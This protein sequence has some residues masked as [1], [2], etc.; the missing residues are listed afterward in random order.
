MKKNLLL[1]IVSLFFTEI[2]F[3]QIMPD[4]DFPGDEIT[5]YRDL[6]GDGYGN[7][8]SSIQSSTQPNGYV[9]N[10]A[11]CDDSNPNI[12][13]EKFW[14]RDSDGDGYGTPS[15]KVLSCTALSGYVS[16]SSDCNDSNA[17]LPKYFYKDNDGDGYG[18][19]S[20]KLLACS[21]PSGYVSNTS[22]CNDSNAS[23]PK[24][25]Y[26]DSDGDGYGTGIGILDCNQPT[27]TNPDGS[28]A[29]SNVNGDCN[30][31]NSN[32][33]PGALEICDGIDNDCDGQI[34]EAPKPSTPSAPT[35]TKNCGSTVLT[36]STP[37]SG[38]T[39]YWQSSS[40][41][42]S[43]GNSNTS[44]TRTSGTVYYL[45][46]R[47]NTTRCWS[48]VRS[49]SYS[50]NTVPSTPP[51]PTITKNCGNTVLTKGSSPSGITWYWQSSSSGT[52]TSNS[53]TSI[54]RTSGTVYYLRARN[55]TSGC[56]SSTRSVSYSINTIPSTP[57]TPIVTKNCGNT[58]L[59]RGTPPSGITWYWQ[60]SS[61]GTSTAN[62]NSSITRTS[63]TVYY[64]RARNNTTGCWSSTR[65]VSYSINTVPSTPSTPTIT[66]NC[67]NTVLTRGTP[68]S[69]ISWYWQSTSSGT[70]TGNSNTSI[71][72]TSGTV[73]YLRARNNTSGC[74]SS[75][76]S[77]SYSINTVPSTPPTP[78]IT[79]NC[80]NT[81][82]TKGSSPSGITWYWQSS[83]SGTNTSN[84]NTSITRTSGTVYYLRARN[85]TSGCWSSVR[86][87]S[88]SINSPSTWYADTDGDGYGDTNNTTSACETPNGYVSNN[89]D[90]DDSTNLITN[91]TPKNYYRDIDNDGYGNLSVKVYQS[92]APT[93][94]VTNS[95]DCNDSNAALHPN[96]KWYADTDGDGFGDPNSVKTQCAQPS[97]YVLSKEDNCPTIKGTYF[98][99]NETQTNYSAP[100]L[101]DENY[102]FI[103]EY[104]EAKATPSMIAKNSDVI[105]N[106]T[107]FDGLGR[108]KQQIAIRGGVKQSSSAAL[109]LLASDWLEGMGSTSFYNQNG[110]TAENQRVLGAS[111][112]GTK[113]VLWLCGNDVTSN[114][115][116]GWNT[117]YINIDN[118]KSYRYTVWVKRTG[119]Q[120][121]TTYHGTQNVNNLS[122]TTNNNPYFWNGDLPQL[123]TWYLL[124]GIIHPAG[125]SGNDTGISGVYDINGTR[126]IDG[127]EFV[128]DSS[129]T[130]SRFRSYLYYST[131]VTTNQYFWNP[132]LET[133][134]GTE[135]SIDAI[136]GTTNT[137]VN[138]IVT[139][140][141]YDEFGRQTKEY[142][143]YAVESANGAIITGD[144]ASATKSFYQVNYSDDF[145]GVSL[146]DVN[147]YSEKQFDGSPLNRVLKQAAPGK[148]W[149][150]GNGHE[151]EFDYSSNIATEVK[152]YY[153]TT[154]LA[155]NTYTPTLELSTVNNG[156]FIAGEL[157]KTVTKDENHNGS[158]SKLHTTEEFK[159][160]Q[161]QV[162]L[163]RTY[164][165]VSGVETAHDTYYVYDDFGNLTYVLP[166]MINASTNT[167][168][169]INSKLNDLGYQYKYDHRN[170]LV[171]KKIP[172]KGWEYI[173]YD[174]LDR[175]V[176]TQDA[177]L[178]AQ[179]KWLF[180]KY[181]ALGRVIYTGIYTHG[182]VIT[183]EAMQTYFDSQNN[184]KEKYYEE[185]LT[186]LGTLGI[187][188]SSSDFPTTNLEVLT[189]NYYDNYTFDRAGAN[190]SVSSTYGVN[191]TGNLKSLATG[192]KV[193]VLGS[194]P[195]KWITTVTYYDE[196][197]RPIYVY[198][199]NEEL[200]T[201]DIIESKLDFSGK[202]LETKTTHTKGTNAPI[203]TIDGFEY[204]HVRRMTKQTQ[205]INNQE[206]E[207]IVANEYDELGQL[208]TKK[209]GGT[210]Q[211]VD[212]TY[213]VRGWLKNINEDG[214]NDNDL[215]NFTLVYEN[216]IDPLKALYN[217]NISQINWNTLSVNNTS[218]PVSSQYEYTY[219]AL[220][221]ITSATSDVG[222]NYNLSG[223]TYDKNGNILSLNR[224][225]YQG[226][227]VFTNMDNLV[228]SYDSG[229]KLNYVTDGGN[230]N[231][232]FIDNNK[233]GNDYYYDVNGN[234]TKDLN[235]NITGIAYNYLNLPLEIKIDNSDS[236]K[237][238]YTYDASG[239]KLRKI[240]NDN[241]NITTLDYANG[242]TY[243]NN[244]LQYFP[245]A[246]GYVKKDNTGFK[247]VYQ[248]KD[249]LG[250][251]RLSYTDNNSDGVITVSSDPNTNEII[252]E[253]SYYP[254]GLKHEGY[255]TAK[256][257]GIGSHIA[258]KFG[259]VGQELE[260]SLNLNLLEMD[261]RQYDSTIGRFNGIDAL[262]DNY[263]D[264]TP[265]HYAHNSPLFLKDPT[266]LFS[267]V[268]NEDG[269]VIDHKDDNDKNIYLGSRTGPVVGEEEEGKEYKKGDKLYEVKGEIDTYF[270]LILK[271]VNVNKEI[272]KVQSL[273][274]ITISDIT[275]I[276]LKIKKNEPL[277]EKEKLIL[278]SKLNL[279]S[280]SS[281]YYKNLIEQK[282]V[283][284]YVFK[285]YNSQ[286]SFS[287]SGRNMYNSFINYFAGLAKANNIIKHVEIPDGTGATL[288]SKTIDKIRDNLKAPA[289][290]A[291]GGVR[292]HGQKLPISFE[293]ARVKN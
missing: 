167:L 127:T 216:P 274:E 67:G 37:P 277:S 224:N 198:S 263:R 252:E 207:T 177:K 105:E 129:T 43:T 116:G 103:R 218:N 234:M 176:L 110:S 155:D 164:A 64:L 70:S 254:F 62:A 147:A 65:S 172:G 255:N 33:K 122:G 89:D 251:V 288:K 222:G 250:N 219:D 268:V 269:E 282:E 214:K 136:V 50:I 85:N 161:G 235:K 126:V 196:K 32:I 243:E 194:S 215:F 53:N 76:R 142:L 236:K 205:K 27:L 182:S 192:S 71:T 221:R 145:A 22:D 293:D 104:Q 226:N 195:A 60:S 40:S 220:N 108:A 264:I 191:S 19:S 106:I 61:S 83:S 121:G 79:K 197:A 88:Y 74:W 212:Y 173:I 80:G 271:E 120:N 213:N 92:N 267:T 163:K 179:N 227:T 6:D 180:T 285:E 138:D 23:L 262:A 11:D 133:V 97:G 49:V 217:G 253:S 241:G 292:L 117:D 168:A 124:V 12:G 276:E 41:G 206:T 260:E 7:P 59:T 273:I 113:E 57:S 193:K 63:G 185:K 54:T 31:D 9:F 125:Y 8:R 279:L 82:L 290:N 256:N 51:T 17:S 278:K 94:Y 286:F 69:G 259:Y 118:T 78:T 56:W 272:K 200:Q 29:Y 130:T 101:S 28:L 42:T 230:N 73:Y 209:V 239:V 100:N 119:S 84:S 265:Y 223:I 157:Y 175:P 128:W 132:V 270:E 72:R 246:E 238:N 199:K 240:I 225:G 146:P 81:V 280:M 115:D 143:P 87:V 91:I 156:N 3:S 249:H 14:Y 93:G 242:Y 46:A 153:V 30:D 154:A 75:T 47:N 245:T 86:S 284:M 178:K 258:Q 109:N 149:K 16:N 289:S 5:W 95:L 134:D 204:D 244:E 112:R 90:Y 131:D 231:Y 291:F 287:E 144:V 24:Y 281:M 152:N 190:T 203:V 48:S 160:K 68:P 141:E 148:D 66:K 257:I 25:W 26:V 187:Y 184:S 170:R 39:W 248:Y 202:V 151:I 283:I 10:G 210:L 183:R 174:K 159:N 165:L 166:P 13:P 35:I 58:V 15:N 208:K 4:P 211:E 266:G 2:L 186:S 171:E 169:V 99:C 150:L 102:V 96:T 275:K 52:N 140:I 44:I 114:A 261:W 229:N 137:K 228:Y 123:D 55:N 111:P 77:V 38:I 181:D 1:I 98:G 135:L 34:D 247:Y 232:G 20:N 201:T 139:H 162:L 45:R 158:S 107:Y 237:I 36:R 188:Y 18:T 21:A 189:V 233:S